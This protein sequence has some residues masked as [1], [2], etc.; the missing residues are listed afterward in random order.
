M[1]EVERGDEFLIF[2]EGSGQVVIYDPN[3]EWE[4]SAESVTGIDEPE[5]TTTAILNRPLRGFRW[6]CSYPENVMEEAFVDDDGINCVIRQV[7]AKYTKHGLTR[8][9]LEAE[10]TSISESIEPE[11]EEGI[12]SVQILARSL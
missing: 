1:A 11:T 3:S 6:P 4:Y 9:E 10:F 12:T 7:C 2:F 8:E 5:V